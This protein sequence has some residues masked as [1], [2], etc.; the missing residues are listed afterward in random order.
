MSIGASPIYQIAPLVGPWDADEDRGQGAFRSMYSK[1][2]EA[3][4]ALRR[5][6][7]EAGAAEWAHRVGAEGYSSFPIELAG[8]CTYSRERDGISLLDVELT[9]RYEP[10]ATTPEP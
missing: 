4:H 7:L 2:M 3:E 9:D 1:A 8:K 6:L 5:A 10:P